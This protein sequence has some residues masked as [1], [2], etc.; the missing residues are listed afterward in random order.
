MKKILLLFILCLA[1]PSLLAAQDTVQYVDDESCGCELVFV[2]GIQTTQQGE[3]FGFKREDGTVIVP[4]KYRFVDKFHG[5]YCKVYLDYNQCGLIDRNGNE[6]I[7]CLY[8]DVNYPTDGMILVQ[9]D[10]LYGF[11]DTSG[12]QRVPFVY[13]AA[14]TYSEG[15][16]VVA[17]DVDSTFV[18]Y[19]F[20]DHDGNI[21]IP[22]TFEYALPY[23]EGFAVVKNYDRYGMID[24]TGREVFPIKFE[25]LTPVFE[26]LFFAGDDDGLALYN[27]KFRQ[28][29]KPIYTSLEGKTEDRIL[30]SRNGKFG[31]LDEKGNEIIPCQYDQAG[32][33]KEGRTYVSINNKWGIIDRQGRTILPI[34]YDNSGFRSQLYIYHEGLALIEKLGQYG[35]VDLE[36]HFLI[37]PCFDDAYHFADGLAPVHVGL[38]GYI[39]TKG[40]FFIP[41]TFDIASPFEWGR[42]EVIY[43]GE[44][45]KMNTE[46]KCVK[47]CKKAPKSW[48][49]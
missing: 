45:H 26:G 27:S 24:R 40:D 11:F 20:I 4:N 35:F 13:R 44:I 9:Q 5:N 6:I 33:F 34:E 38:W 49:Q 42:A 14:S 31:F 48:R 39:D 10:S 28:L 19:G 36:G 47:N 8:T 3:L 15:T 16:A 22:P 12:R 17:I 21:V 18:G 46:G 23:S 7:P 2:N 30:V 41:P 1:L 32:L 29:T 37:Y 43:R 25:I